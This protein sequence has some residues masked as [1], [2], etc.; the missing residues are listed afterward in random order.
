M[1]WLVLLTAP[2]HTV[3]LGPVKPLIKQVV[4]RYQPG[5]SPL[6]QP[7]L[8]LRACA[9]QAG[10]QAP[11]DRP[12]EIRVVRSKWLNQ[13]FER[14][15]SHSRTGRYYATK[16]G[17]PALIYLSNEGDGVLTLAHEWMHHLAA[18]YRR[19]WSEQE[20][21]RRAEACAPKAP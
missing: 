5:V 14:P 19:N 16:G 11:F 8:T 9:R 20:V 6:V 2:A 18:I 1:F 4:L 15:V 17:H 3:Q 21:E 7:L 13:A 10:L 12:L